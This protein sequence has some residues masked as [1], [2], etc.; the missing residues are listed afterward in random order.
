[1]ATQ[2]TSTSRIPTRSAFQPTAAALSDVRP[3]EV[4]IPEDIAGPTA[5]T[6][7]TGSSRVGEPLTSVTE[8][9]LRKIVRLPETNPAPYHFDMRGQWE[10]TVTAISGDEFT[11]VLRDLM[12]PKAEEYDATFAIEEI[13]DEDR[14]LL[15]IGAIF[16]WTIGYRVLHRQ[17][18]RVSEIRFRRLPA[19]SRADIARVEKLSRDLDAMF[20]DDA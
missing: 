2:A 15:Q 20:A 13:S 1:V 3:E 9:A 11:V 18:L 6:A 14:D 10:G 7:T 16:Y 4:L 5:D 17:R 8:S 12:G 19:W